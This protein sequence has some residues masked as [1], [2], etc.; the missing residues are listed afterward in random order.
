MV[1]LLRSGAIRNYFSSNSKRRTAKIAKDAEKYGTEV[2]RKL[3]NRY[4]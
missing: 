3:K 4:R 1:L 2:F